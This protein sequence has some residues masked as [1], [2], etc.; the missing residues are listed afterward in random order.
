MNSGTDWTGSLESAASGTG[1][2]PAEP[3]RSTSAAQLSWSLLAHWPLAVTRPLGTGHEGCCGS[4]QRSDLGRSAYEI[5]RPHP[6]DAAYSA[7]FGDEE[8]N[9]TASVGCGPAQTRRDQTRPQMSSLCSGGWQADSTPR[10]HN[11]GSP[12]SA[13]RKEIDGQCDD[14]MP[15]C[16]ARRDMPAS[17]RGCGACGLTI[18]T[19]PIGW[20]KRHCC[21]GACTLNLKFLT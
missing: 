1:I 14:Q 6:Q 10:T 16:Y 11:C 18:Y 3:R 19:D 7:V 12:A 17:V 4:T 8:G 13:S 5:D 21:E 9:V 15:M 2:L 20:L